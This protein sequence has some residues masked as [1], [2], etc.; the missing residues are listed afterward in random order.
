MIFGAVGFVAGVVAVLAAGTETAAAVAIAAAVISAVM[1]FVAFMLDGRTCIG[2]IGLNEP[3][4]GAVLGLLGL[5]L[6]SP[7]LIAAVTPFG[8]PKA[9]GAIVAAWLGALIGGL[10]VLGN[11]IEA[12]IPYVTGRNTQCRA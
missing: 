12:L 5:R 9:E 8:D 3:C 4:L 10:A 1:G 11:D 2:Q 6:G 7:E